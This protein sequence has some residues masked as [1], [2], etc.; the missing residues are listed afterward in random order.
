M[1]KR[2]TPCEPES[3]TAVAAKGPKESLHRIREGNRDAPVAV[4]GCSLIWLSRRTRPDVAYGV[5]LAA[6][7]ITRD[8]DECNTGTRHLMQ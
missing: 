5:S 2:E 8:I 4:F 1:R 6:S 3:Y 7:L